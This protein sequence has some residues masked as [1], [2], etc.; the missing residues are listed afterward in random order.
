MDLEFGIPA[1][2]ARVH[3]AQAG[4]IL[5]AGFQVLGMFPERFQVRAAQVVRDIHI[6]DAP[7][8]DRQNLVHADSEVGKSLN[9]LAGQIHDLALVQ[10][11]LGVMREGDEN[12][13]LGDRLSYR[14]ANLG[15]QMVHPGKGMD[16]FFNLACHRVGL[17]QRIAGRGLDIDFKL[18]PV[19]AGHQA[20][21]DQAGNK[22]GGNKHA[23]G[24]AD[25]RPTMTHRPLQHGGI[26]TIDEPVEA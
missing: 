9:L 22:R 2:E 1:L 12:F 13:R 14:R 20:G 19:V 18:P 17:H 7:A 21:A 11:P 25:N 26:G 3:I 5:G 23:Q 24:E 8:A 16:F 4:H 6:L 15:Q 10:V